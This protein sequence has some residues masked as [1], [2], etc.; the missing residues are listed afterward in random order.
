MPKCPHCGSKFEAA[1]DLVEHFDKR[2][3]GQL[4]DRRSGRT[5]GDSIRSQGQRIRGVVLHRSNAEIFEKSGLGGPRATGRYEHTLQYEYDFEGRSYRGT[6]KI[7]S[8]TYIIPGNNLAVYI[9]PGEPS[10]S[11]IDWKP[12]AR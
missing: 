3:T 6:A 7:D 2:H 8:S 9:K 10:K 12:V 11:A 1:E 4:S 5:A